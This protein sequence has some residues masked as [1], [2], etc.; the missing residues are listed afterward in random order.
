MI[1]FKAAPR[2][3]ALVALG[4]LSY[5]AGDLGAT[6]AGMAAAVTALL[7]NVAASVIGRDV[8][9]EGRLSAMSIT[10]VSM[11]TPDSSASLTCRMVKVPCTPVNS[12]ITGPSKTRSKTDGAA[13]EPPVTWST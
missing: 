3:P 8:N 7:A 10:A 9:R 11:P 1:A 4:A 6:V 5:F 13:P 12:T 2:L